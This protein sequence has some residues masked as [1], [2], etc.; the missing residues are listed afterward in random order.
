MSGDQSANVR[1]GIE[2]GKIEKETEAGRVGAMPGEPTEQIQL[3]LLG[4]QK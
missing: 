4:G 1:V 2:T 3:H